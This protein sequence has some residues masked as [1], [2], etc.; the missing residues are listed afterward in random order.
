MSRNHAKKLHLHHVFVFA[1][2]VTWKT[3]YTLA[4]MHLLQEDFQEVQNI[5]NKYTRIEKTHNL[6]I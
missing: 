2:F 6:K 5:F 1:C 3:Y 4:L